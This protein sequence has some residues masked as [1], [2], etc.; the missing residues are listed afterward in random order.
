MRP[1]YALAPAARL[2][3]NATLIVW[4]V[5][6]VRQSRRRR[7]DAVDQDA[8]SRNVIRVTIVTAFFLAGVASGVRWGRI[9]APR[10]ELFAVGIVLMWAGIGFRFWAFATLGR[11]FT[12]TV[13]TS[14]DQPVVSSGPYRIVRH[15]SYAGALL[16]LIGIAFVQGSWL[17]LAV[18]IVIPAV[19][20][21][22]RIRVEERALVAALGE[23]YVAYAAGRKRLMPFVW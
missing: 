15:P 3:F 6:E 7:H 12:F 22:N 1:L 10:T 13:M 8:G 16:A 18:N 21:V 4:L 23:P 14:A 17:S 2:L 20:M 11:Y 5:A 19:G 9:H